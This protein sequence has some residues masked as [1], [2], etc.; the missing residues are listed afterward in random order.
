VARKR[1]L[2]TKLPERATPPDFIREDL[3]VGVKGFKAIHDRLNMRIAPLTLIS[4]I[5]SAGK[6][7]FMQPLLLM[8]QTLDAG[9][10][11]GAL[12]IHGAN[13]KFTDRS[14]TL[15]RGKS[16]D[17]Q[18][19]EFSVYLKSGKTERSVTYADS[20]EGFRIASD[21]IVNNRV[22][23]KLTEN[24][25]P[26]DVENL[27]ENLSTFGRIVRDSYSGRLTN[28]NPETIFKTVLSVTR[29]RCFLEAGFSIS[30]P[31]EELL[32]ELNLDVLDSHTENW[33]QMLRDIIHVPGLRGNPERE[34]PRAAAGNR[35]PG[36]FDPYVASVV[37]GWGEKNDVRLAALSSDMELLG[38][39]WKVTARRKND[40]TIEVLVGRLPHSQQ[41]GAH[42]LV[43]IADVGFGISQTLPV[44]VA[45][46]AAHRGQ[47]VYIEQP[48]IHLHPRA[49]IHLGDLLVRAANRGVKVVVET[50]S[51]LLIR[52]I[53]TQLALKRIRPESVSLNWFGRNA[54]TGYATIE[55]AEIDD[56]GRFG[57]WPLDFD[58]V[59]LEA[60]MAYLNAVRAA[61]RA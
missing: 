48:E 43:S 13:A 28:A 55:A 33:A 27:E 22:S 10:D 11:P 38:L 26:R 23:I 9:F 57:K 19:R 59:A 46:L 20:S 29:D 49:Q 5:N 41:G 1:N 15:S 36:T 25:T 17:S 54:E 37:L 42:D 16:R 35:Y 32:T 7:S 6:S 24:M 56:R 2:K 52:A 21:C 3:Y 45:L 4:G 58:E 39:T 50:H 31:G 34:Y 61:E 30:A 53:Q 40:A 51:S 12:L 18:V 14:Q 44:V 60:D 47:V 8:K